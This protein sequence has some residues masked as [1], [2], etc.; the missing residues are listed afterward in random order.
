[1]PQ[2]HHAAGPGPRATAEEIEAAASQYV[3]KVSGRQT[4]AATTT[5]P[6]STRAVQQVTA[7]T[8]A[9]LSD[10]AAPPPAS[11]HAAAAQEDRRPSAAVTAAPR[12][13]C[14]RPVVSR[15]GYLASATR[16][17]ST[18]GV[19]AGEASSGREVPGR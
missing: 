12:P 18:E 11:A 16:R 5:R 2:H 14:S 13:I 19:A 10:F 9:T 15:G 7:A 8:S 4:I 3:R 17:F 1:M 6:H